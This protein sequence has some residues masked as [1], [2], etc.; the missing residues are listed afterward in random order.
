MKYKKLFLFLSIG[1]LVIFLLINI[2][3]SQSDKKDNQ[4]LN[5]FTFSQSVNKDQNTA[6]NQKIEIEKMKKVIEVLQS[7]KENKTLVYELRRKLEKQNL[8]DLI[9]NKENFKTILKSLNY[10][11]KQKDIINKN[12]RDQDEFFESTYKFYLYLTI[13]NLDE[14]K[15]SKLKEQLKFIKRKIYK[16][17]PEVIENL[18]LKNDPSLS[19]LVQE[20]EESL[21]QP[22]LSKEKR[23]ALFS[24]I[25]RINYILTLYETF[26]YKDD[27]NWVKENKMDILNKLKF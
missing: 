27:F 19:S 24:E 8:F 4:N 20:I 13:S 25:K 1:C 11:Q 9:S 22:G 6:G 16:I 10:T 2:I 21:Y 12:F 3:L 18:K 7:M 26:Q 23:E 17:D 14:S 5:N 15:I